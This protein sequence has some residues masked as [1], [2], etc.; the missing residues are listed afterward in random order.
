MTHFL[1]PLYSRRNFALCLFLNRDLQA[2]ARQQASADL[3]EEIIKRFGHGRMRIDHVAQK[4][5]VLTGAH[6]GGDGID[7]F[8]GVRAVQGA[9]ENRSAVRV[10]HGLE[11]AAGLA[12]QAGARNGRGGQCGNRDVQSLGAGFLLEPLELNKVNLP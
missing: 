7:H 9:T 1:R 12:E 4:G 8:P 5:G 10:R 6:G 11:Q 2:P 3:A